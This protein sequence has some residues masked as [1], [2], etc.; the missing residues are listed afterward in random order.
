SIVPCGAVTGLTSQWSDGE[1]P[2]H[3]AR[4]L[5]TLEGK[6]MPKLGVLV[7]G[8]AALV[9]FCVTGVKIATAQSFSNDPNV[10]LVDNC[11]PQT[12]NVAI[13]GACA[14]TPHRL[15]TTFAEFVGLL[16]SPLAQNIVGH[17]AWNFQPGYISVRAGQRVKATNTGGEGHTFTEV[18]EFGGGF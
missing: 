10:S 11:D 5:T 3:Q 2:Q 9:G 18:A 17:P 16:F 8:L 13:P 1:C 7:I 14:S 4:E 12:F 15:D 6:T